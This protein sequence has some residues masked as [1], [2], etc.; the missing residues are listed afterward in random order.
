MRRA[1]L[2]ARID[3]GQLTYQS[4]MLITVLSRPVPW[5][6]QTVLSIS[7][8]RG[9]SSKLLRPAGLS[10][11]SGASRSD[12]ARPVSCS[13]GVQL[14]RAD[15]LLLRELITLPHACRWARCWPPCS[16]TR[17]W[18]VLKQQICLCPGP[19]RTLLQ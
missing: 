5:Q 14:T 3:D 15:Q 1:R 10:L 11:P 12:D 16:R 17:P 6:D 13:P 2:P 8:L 9:P 18:R 4:R 7:E 19:W